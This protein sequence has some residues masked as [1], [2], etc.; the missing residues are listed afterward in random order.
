MCP[1]F[2]K[3]WRRR[4]RGEV[5]R[6]AFLV[7]D[8]ITYDELSGYDRVQLSIHG[9]ERVSV[10]SVTEYARSV[11]GIVSNK[12]HFAP[13]STIPS[14]GDEEGGSVASVL[15][16]GRGELDGKAASSVDQESI[17]KSHTRY[18]E[19][20]DNI[21]WLSRVCEVFIMSLANVAS[22]ECDDAIHSRGGFW[23]LQRWHCI[24]VGIG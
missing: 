16:C 3:L 2:M 5:A 17:S 7:A 8:S 4:T 10:K 12:H 9:P 6:I 1:S 14:L 19:Q 11:L 20:G 22:S 23:Q 21:R 24:S 18:I 15:I 13:L